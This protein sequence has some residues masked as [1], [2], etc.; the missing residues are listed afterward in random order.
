VLS[1]WQEDT[2]REEKPLPVSVFEFAGA[3]LMIYPNSGGLT[4]AWRFI[5]RNYTIE[6]NVNAGKRSGIIRGK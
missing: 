6:L 4:S 3:P 2:R 1:A 5:P